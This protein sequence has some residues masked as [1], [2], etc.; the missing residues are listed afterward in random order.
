MDGCHGF[1]TVRAK[2]R[3]MPCHFVRLLRSFLVEKLAQFTQSWLPSKNDF[4]IYDEVRGMSNAM[5]HDYI[6]MFL[7]KQ[8]LEWDAYLLELVL[9]A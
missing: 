7:D 4:F 5:G 8:H 1:E 6:R 9:Q 2:T 3:V